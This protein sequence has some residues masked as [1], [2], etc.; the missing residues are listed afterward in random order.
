MDIRVQ[1]MRNF[2]DSAHSTYH[3]V[4]A[5]VWELEDAGYQ[6]LHEGDDWNLLPGG[7]YYVTRGGSSVIAFRIP[8]DLASGFMI[9]AGHTDRPAFK[10]KENYELTGKYTRLAV[11]RYG[12]MIMSTWM[13]RPLSVAGRVVVQTPEGVESRLVDID[14]D[15]LII[16]SMAIHMNREVNE[17]YRWNPA[18]D[19]L[20]LLGGSNA[21]GKLETLIENEAGGKV[22]GHDL[23]LYVRQGSSLVGMDEEYICAPAL[24]DLLCDWCCL[25]GFLDS[26]DSAA[27]PVLCLFDNEEVGSRSF[28]GAGSDFM[29]SVLLRICRKMQ[30]DADRMLSQSFMVSADNGHALHPNHPEFADTNNAPV[31]GEGMLIKYSAS[32]TYTTDGITS[33]IVRRICDMAHIPLQT[34]CNRADLRGGSTLG[35]ISIGKVSVPSVDIGLP[36][37]AMHS[38]YETAGVGDALDMVEFMTTYYSLSLESTADGVYRLI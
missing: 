19:M 18:V 16:P 12:G 34:Y 32:M 11:E 2:L 9:S 1:E 8:G 7:K 37:L 36:Q 25:R 30:W 21:Q 10:I 33:A 6:P 22:L 4:A 29:E 38:T 27:V 13:D 5:V 14:R 3:T 15:L 31:I 35:N 26:K 20:P 24:D 23:Y 28:Q 17:G